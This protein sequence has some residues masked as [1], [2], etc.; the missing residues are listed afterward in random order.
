M[1]TL[2][3]MVAELLPHEP[4]Q[5]R[6]LVG[7]EVEVCFFDPKTMKPLGYDGDRGLGRILRAVADLSRAMPLLALSVPVVVW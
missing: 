5:E 7:F 4:R 1:L 2:D 3:E 6:L